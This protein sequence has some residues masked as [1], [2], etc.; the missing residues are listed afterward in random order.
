MIRMLKLKVKIH[1]QRMRAKKSKILKPRRKLG[2]NPTEITHMKRYPF[3]LHP[4]SIA[5]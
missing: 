4:C 5:N 3:A 1:S 2:S